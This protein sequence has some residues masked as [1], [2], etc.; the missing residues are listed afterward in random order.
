MATYAVQGASGTLT[1]SYKGVGVTW[2]SAT[3]KRIKWYEIIMGSAANPNATD[4]YIQVDVSR[5]ATTTGLAGTAWT[6]TATDPADGAA[7]TLSANLLTTEPVIT[8]NSSL[9]NF[10]INQRATTRWIAAQ[11]SQYLIVPATAQSGLELR[12]QSST[13]TGSVQGQITFLE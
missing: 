2:V 3:P 8:A 1:S 12:A 6:P 11:E 4:T 9:L 5:L 13:F 7:L 10:G